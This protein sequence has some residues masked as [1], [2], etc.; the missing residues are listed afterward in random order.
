M[1][2]IRIDLKDAGLKDLLARL[3]ERG[4]DLSPLMAELAAELLQSTRRRFETESAPEGQ[5]WPPL[6]KGTL[7]QRGQNARALRKSGRLYQSIHARAGKDE[8]LVGTNVVYA[9]IHQFGGEVQHFARS[10][11]QA[12]NA[13]GRFTKKR[14]TNRRERRVTIGEHAVTIPARPFFGVSSRDRDDLADGMR[15]YLV[16]IT[17]EA[18]GSTAP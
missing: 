8:A 18:A 5:S 1:T 4:S 12:V 10:Q 16:R 3:V 7:K 13:S 15:R 14:K 2:Q 6:S 9:A 17:D 11:V